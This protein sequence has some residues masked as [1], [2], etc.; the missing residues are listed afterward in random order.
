MG[1][2]PIAAHY[3]EPP[4]EAEVTE[5]ALDPATALVASLLEWS[6]KGE[7]ED[8]TGMHNK[9]TQEDKWE[10]EVFQCRPPM[11]VYGDSWSLNGEMWQR[12]GEAASG[13]TDW[14][15]W[16]LGVNSGEAPKRVLLARWPSQDQPRTLTQGKRS[17]G[18]S[19]DMIVSVVVEALDRAGS[20]ESALG[21][22]YM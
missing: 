14:G 8:T 10:E 3:G 21:K 15:M 16:L 20:R 11:K 2:G 4:G 13:M 6:D 9:R 1:L 22:V 17:L 18:R 12:H 19:A 5:R 7:Q